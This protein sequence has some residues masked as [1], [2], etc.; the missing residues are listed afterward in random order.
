MNA[1]NR[2]SQ[3]LIE[4]YRQ[5][6]F[7][8]IFLL[9]NFVYSCFILALFGYFLWD[10][11][12]VISEYFKLDEI[13]RSITAQKFAVPFFFGLSLIVLFILNTLWISVRLTHQFYGPL[14]SIHRFLDD[15]IANRSISPIT[16]RKNDQLQEVAARL[17]QLSEQLR[18]R[19]SAQYDES[20]KLILSFL[21]DLL[22]GKVPTPLNLADGDYFKET[23]SKLN[24]LAKL[25]MK[26]NF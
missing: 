9:I 3:L 21:S 2:R 11:H 6:K 12:D 24:Q 16:L 22:A 15:L 7:G 5:L 17:N 1:V 26:V 23:A 4:P 14:I 13:Q 19:N 20:H 10:M 18:A 8:V 25:K